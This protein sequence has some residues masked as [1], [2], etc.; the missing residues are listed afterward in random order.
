MNAHEVPRV[1]VI[2]A[3]MSGIAA[4]HYLRQKGYRP[5]LLDA[6]ST[7]GGR[8]SSM[9]LAGR[10]IDIGGKNIGRRYRRFREFLTHYGSPTLEYF[11]INSSTIK[12][13]R[14]HTLDSQRKLSSLWHVLKLVGPRDFA[15]LAQ[16]AGWVRRFPEE[17]MLGGA[18]FGALSERKDER[19]L[20]E[21]FS[22]ATCRYF[23]RPILLRMNGA[24][25]DQYFLGCL[26]SNLKMLF[27]S[28]DQLSSGM[29]SVLD[30]FSDEVSVCLGTR[31][32]KLL[33]SGARVTGVEVERHGVRERRFYDAVV[34]ALPA[35]LSAELLDGQPIQSDLR[36]IAYHPVTLVVARYRRPIFDQRVRAI[37]FGPESPL[38]N[39]GCYGKQS[40]DIV[41]YTLS[42][43]AAGWIDERSDPERV[44]SRAE[45]E[46]GRFVPIERSQRVDFVFK[47]FRHGLCAYGP[48]H[49]RFL[50]RLTAW[51]GSVAG[52]FLAGDYV[53]GASIEACFQSSF[54]CVE[55]L[56]ARAPEERTNDSGVR[57]GFFAAP[58]SH[59][60]LDPRVGEQP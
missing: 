31:A 57:S 4:A 5:E 60:G 17:G 56:L 3:G 44:L 54:E 39:A 16:L 28:Y 14:L 58:S 8:A 38:S 21:W 15:R 20:S 9:P 11:G 49:H 51:E 41:R 19:P 33:W 26:G 23:L 7:L 27:D 59:A 13:G 34:L 6:G 24:E 40:L 53:R 37:V 29:S 10:S 25:P 35:A 32:A 47:H 30:R 36:Q 22:P 12:D 52:L 2:G 1:A 55:R 46:L 50:E 43:R 18:R 48:Y 45:A 42:G